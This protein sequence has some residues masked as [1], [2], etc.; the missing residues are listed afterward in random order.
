[1]ANSYVRYTGNGTTTD[2]TFPFPYIS[3]DHVKVSVDG[4]AAVFTFLNANTVKITPAPT[5]VIDIRRVTPKDNPPVNFQDGSVLKEADLDLLALF[6]TYIAQEVQDTVDQVI[7]VNLAGNLD[8]QNKRVI[9]VA[10]PVDDQDAVNKRTLV[11]DYPKVAIVADS[12]SNVNKVANDLNGASFFE[13]DL[14]SITDTPTGLPVADGAINTVAINITAVE[15]VATNMSSVTSA[16]TNAANAADSATASASSAT[17]S[18]SSASSASSSAS[19][20]ATQAS[21][22][23]ASASAASGSASAAAASA[24]TATT[25]A[26]IATTKAGEAATSATNA[27]NSATAAGS[28]QAAAE[29][30]RD[31]TL[32]AYDN[33][34]DRYLG[35]KASDPTVDNDGNALVG[36]SLY[37]N[38]TTQAMKV[39][40]GSAWV[41]AYIAGTNVLMVANNL[42]DL[43][44]VATARTNLGLST[45]AATGSYNDLSSKPTLGS[46]AAKSNVSS[47]DL[48]SSLDLGTVP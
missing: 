16:L 30:A 47:S 15:D 5:G 3:Q 38:T 20:A 21:N 44:N 29:A 17:A 39:Y 19:S 35:A 33:F 14:G 43:A 41:A 6:S 25:Q 4:V 26:G 18:A 24:T 28:A 42:S 7:Q 9:N 12:V 36:G 32:M 37:F 13:A 23:S 45:V 1:M 22:A 40:T 2:Y 8:A 10:D 48:A 34:D 46:L 27:A 31:A 11:Y